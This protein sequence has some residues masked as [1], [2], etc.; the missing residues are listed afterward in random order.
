M[1]SCIALKTRLMV[2][3]MMISPLI[4][5]L[6]AQSAPSTDIGPL[7]DIHRRDMRCATVFAIVAQGQDEGLPSALEYPAMEKR[8]KEYFTQLGQRI[9]EETGQPREAVRQEFIAV[10]QNIQQEAQE[11]GDPDGVSAKYM[12]QCLPLLDAAIPQGDKPTLPQCSVYL[13]LAYEEIYAREGLSPAAQDMKT[14]A[15]VLSSRTR[16][17]LRAQD[18][19]TFEID[20]YMFQV[21]EGILADLT[22]DPDQDIDYDHCFEL[23]QP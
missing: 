18:K 14:L 8:G 3:I 2:A 17:M 5:A 12:G 1:Q 11:S 4:A 16:D 15:T 20:T 7:T 22:A 19:T 9:V 21:R 10:A 6:L 23:A 13:Q